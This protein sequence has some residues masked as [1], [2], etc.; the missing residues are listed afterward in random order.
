MNSAREK[1]TWEGDHPALM[2]SDLRIWEESPTQ[3]MVCEFGR[4]QGYKV[5]CKERH[6]RETGNTQ[7][8][9]R[10]HR[11]QTPGVHCP[12]LRSMDVVLWPMAPQNSKEDPDASLEAGILDGCLSPV[13][14]PNH[15]KVFL[16]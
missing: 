1:S 9:P 8:Q 12:L 6:F 3:N 5:C 10:K 15:P 2:C 4:P 11:S 13:I 16:R 14:F 7:D